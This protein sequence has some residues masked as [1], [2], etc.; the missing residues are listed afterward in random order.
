[1]EIKIDNSIYDVSKFN[2][3]GGDMITQGYGGKDASGLFHMNH[4]QSVINVLDKY[5]K[6]DITENKSNMN[7][8]SKF[9]FDVKDRVY[10]YMK[11]KN[12]TRRD[13]KLMVF[14]TGLILYLWLISYLNCFY[15]GNYFFGFI[16]GVA[17]AM[18]LMNVMHDLNHGASRILS[19]NL[20]DM[21]FGSTSELWRVQHNYG[22]HSYTNIKS[23]DPDIRTGENDIRRITRFEKILNIHKYQYI[24]LPIL[25]GLLVVKSVLMDD[26]VQLYNQ[27]IGNIY[28]GFDDRKV[29]FILLKKMGYFM[30]YGLFPYLY[31]VCNSIV[32][33]NIFHMVVTGYILAYIF[34]VAHVNDKVRFIKDKEDENDWALMQMNSSVNFASNSIFWNFFSGGLNNQIEHHLFP[35]VH[36]TYYLWISKIVKEECEKHNISYMEYDTFWDALKGH[37]RHMK[38]MGYKKKKSKKLD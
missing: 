21:I 38:N 19:I 3:P 12:L 2:H 23:L 13:E 20:V 29:R 5:K 35:N 33:V 37:F 9:Y 7:Y 24:Y 14:K 1:M 4:H 22:H 8:R 10:D 34:Q 31:G 18:G 26:F 16:L 36:H 32:Y 25:Y 28:L 11:K 17:N 30:I 15:Y 6:D 27:F